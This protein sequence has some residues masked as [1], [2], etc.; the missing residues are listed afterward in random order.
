MPVV[1]L[2][3]LNGVGKSTQQEA[4]AEL[5][6]REFPDMSVYLLRDPGVDTGHDAEKIRSLATQGEWKHTMTRELL[7]MAARCELIEHVRNLD[8]PDTLILLDRYVGSYYAYGLDAF[9]EYTCT[10]GFDP[11]RSLLETCNAFCPDVTIIMQ[12]PLEVAWERRNSVRRVSDVRVRSGL[13]KMERCAEIYE[14][15]ITHPRLY[16][17]VGKVIVR[18]SIQPEMESE[19]VA[20]KLWDV[21][22]TYAFQERD[23]LYGSSSTTR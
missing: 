4:L 7:F 19:Y 15:I 10:D 5:A 11:I 9:F 3:G 12:L 20:G 16:P 21:I 18:A 22:K 1:C 17:H 23:V 6:R 2:E 8:S 14:H 13:D